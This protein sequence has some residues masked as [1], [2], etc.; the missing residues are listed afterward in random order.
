[1]QRGA[2]WL[3]LLLWFI[4]PGASVA[5]M[6]DTVTGNT[7]NGA[8]PFGEPQNTTFGQTFLVGP[9]TVLDSFS[10]W[11]GENLNSHQVVSFNAYIMA[12]NG[13]TVSGPVLYQSPTVSSTSFE[14]P[15]PEKFTFTTG[16]LELA[17]KQQYVAFISTSGLFDGIKSEGFAGFIGDVYSGGSF[18]FTTVSNSSFNT[19]G[20]A[21]SHQLAFWSTVWGSNDL[22]FQATFS[23]P[24]ELENV[25]EPC[26]LALLG[27]GGIGMIVGAASRRRQR[28]VAD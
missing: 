7:I 19:H 4:A 6:I 9:D 10:F 23:P 22:A 21:G 13:T 27:I 28:C 17:P 20:L 26:S 16:G 18:V 25:P 24:A 5:S 1:M 8:S 12:W 11:V 14:I 15:N 2:I 3:G